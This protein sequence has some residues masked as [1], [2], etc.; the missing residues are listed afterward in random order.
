M[1]HLS[2]NEQVNLSPMILVVREALVHL[3]LREHRQASRREAV[4]GFAIL[5]KADDI[6]HSNPST[7]HASVA[8][9][10]VRRPNDVS[11]GLGDLGHS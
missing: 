6:V 11:I 5:Q 9:A 10:H 8:T 1:R 2:R 7:F 4:E 3:G